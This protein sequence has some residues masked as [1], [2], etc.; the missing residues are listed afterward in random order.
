MGVISEIQ[1]GIKTVLKSNEWEKY[2]NESIESFAKLVLDSKT[3]QVAKL[4][5]TTFKFVCSIPDI[6]F[7]G[8]VH[9]FF[10]G[11]VNDFE[12]QLK[13]SQ[14]LEADGNGDDYVK[15]VIYIIDSID[16]DMKLDYLGIW[17]KH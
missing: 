15:R 17:L 7:W 16:D 4:A 13:L 14:L 1:Q 8:K 9:R 2:S 5:S 10:C 12:W 6:L 3:F 11:D